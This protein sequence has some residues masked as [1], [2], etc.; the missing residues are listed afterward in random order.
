MA[1][2]DELYSQIP[3]Q[4]IA[5]M[6]GVDAGEVD[7]VVKTLVPALVGSLHHTAQQ[8]PDTA[9]RIESAAGDHAASGLLD[10]GVNVDQVDQDQGNQEISRIFGGNDSGQVA[11]ALAG[12]GAGNG[13]LIQK[14]LPLL[15]PIVLAYIGKQLTHATAGAPGQQGGGGLGNIL[16]GLLGGGAGGGGGSNPLGNILSGVLGGKQGGAIGDVLG[17]L[18]G[19]GK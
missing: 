1:N 3:T 4:Q 2:L 15:A 18:L 7:N 13:A 11:F 17:S 6:L 14:M 9:T 10:G 16:G 19:G 5:S 8:D 12:A